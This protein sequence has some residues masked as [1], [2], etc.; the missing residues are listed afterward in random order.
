[1][2]IRA[3]RST[4]TGQEDQNQKVSGCGEGR[5]TSTT[6]PRCPSSSFFT[7]TA[8]AL[9]T[10]ESRILPDW[11]ERWLFFFISCTG[12]SRLPRCFLF[13]VDDLTGLF[14][15][16]LFLRRQ[17]KCKESSIHLIELPAGACFEGRSHLSCYRWRI[18]APPSRATLD[19]VQL[20]TPFN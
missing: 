9:F 2:G 12:A 13:G 15:S 17:G 5:D 11:S 18:V 19:V 20:F 7:T 6:T 3:W 8:A 14:L 1:M 4:I 10:G 16:V